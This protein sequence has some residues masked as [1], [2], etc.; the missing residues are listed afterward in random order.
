VSDA[1]T[2][3][4]IDSLIVCLTF[5]DEA[6]EHRLDPD[7][8]V[9]VQEWVAGVLGRLSKDDQAALA[10]LLR[11]RAQPEEYAEH[12]SARRWLLGLAAGYGPPDEGAGP[13]MT[14]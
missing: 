4:L 1:V 10:E 7:D 8:A 9:K 13:E 2:N 11:T 12:P 3:A 14:G 5:L 6:P